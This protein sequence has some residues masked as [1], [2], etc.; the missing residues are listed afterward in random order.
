MATNIWTN[1]ENNIERMEVWCRPMDDAL[2]PF[3][4][5]YVQPWANYTR[6]NV[7]QYDYANPNIRSDMFFMPRPVLNWGD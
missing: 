1:P 4:Y 5:P 7:T 2:L 6:T 3:K